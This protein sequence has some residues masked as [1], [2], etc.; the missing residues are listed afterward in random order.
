MLAGSKQAVCGPNE[1]PPVRP[2]HR[3][4]LA[5]LIRE[6]PLF[7]NVARRRWRVSLKG[8]NW[9][10]YICFRGVFSGEGGGS[11]RDRE[12]ADISDP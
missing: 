2:G 12:P 1:P 6:R 4:Q 9:G 11:G 5:R 8:R 3:G 7:V 10:E